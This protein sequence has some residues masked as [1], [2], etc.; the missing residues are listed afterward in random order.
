M[1]T[2]FRSLALA[3]VILFLFASI[4][5]GAQQR[6]VPPPQIPYGAP[7]NLDQAK[8][9]MA[10]AESEAK[11]IKLGV[12]I[13]VLDS[14]G[15]VVMLQ[16]LDGA[17]LGSIE[18]SQDKA[19]SAVFFRRPTKVFQDRLADGGINLRLLQLNGA[20]VIEGGIPIIVDGKVVGAVG[21]S[22]GLVEQD[23]QIARAGVDALTK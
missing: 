13:V 6:I 21:V 15:H 22:G 4:P 14:G 9:V 20:N 3:L 10:G 5:V 1:T 19:H 8:K 2:G 16:R 11:K 7:L 18:A 12:V 23:T 17:Q